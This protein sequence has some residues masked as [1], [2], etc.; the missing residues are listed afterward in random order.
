[1][2]AT[3]EVV[4]AD[5]DA[6]VRRDPAQDSLHRTAH[7]RVAAAH[8]HAVVGVLH[9]DDAVGASLKVAHVAQVAGTVG[10]GAVVALKRVPVQTSAV[11]PLAQVAK[12]V[13]V[14]AVLARGGAGDLV[15]AVNLRFLAKATLTVPVSETTSDQA[16]WKKMSS[17]LTPGWPLPMMT[18]ALRSLEQSSP[19]SAKAAGTRAKRA[20]LE[21]SMSSRVGAEDRG[22]GRG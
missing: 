17:P 22:R 11:A 15:S 6:V 9:V 7:D 1:M 21:K 13:D 19:Q 2:S 5:M 4:G 16:R 20:S 10:R 8:A 18:L 12:G 3:A 14:H